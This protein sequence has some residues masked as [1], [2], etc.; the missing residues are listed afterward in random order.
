[1]SEKPELYSMP[2]LSLRQEP[3]PVKGAEMGQ[4]RINRKTER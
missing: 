1:M 4:L 3:P 2:V